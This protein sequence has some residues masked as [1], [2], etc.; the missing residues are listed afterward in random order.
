MGVSARFTTHNTS[1]P[2]LG[3]PRIQREHSPANAAWRIA[4]HSPRQQAG[5]GA[6]KTACVACVAIHYALFTPP[7]CWGE[8]WRI[9]AGCS[10][11]TVTI[12][13]PTAWRYIS[14]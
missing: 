5:G 6:A 11:P 1:L 13:L 14:C 2:S 8:L 12:C 4:A 10:L 9:M 3:T 7:A